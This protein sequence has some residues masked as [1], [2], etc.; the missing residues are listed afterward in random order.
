[1]TYVGNDIAKLSHFAKAISSDDEKLMKPFK[2][3]NDSYG[4]QMLYR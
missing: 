2:F 3:V 4:L 1:M